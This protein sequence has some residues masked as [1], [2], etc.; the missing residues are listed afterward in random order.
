V[1]VRHHDIRLATQAPQET[2]N[3]AAGTVMRQIYL[4]SHRDYLVALANGEAVR[5]VAP[6]DLAIDKGQPVWLHFPP[7]QCRALAH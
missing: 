1:S 5:T 3:W 7:E 6:A 4:G 2:L